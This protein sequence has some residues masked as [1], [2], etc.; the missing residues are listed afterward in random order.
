M[1]C[2]DKVPGVI[3]RQI[4]NALILML[5]FN[6]LVW[7]LCL[8]ICR[9]NGIHC[10]LCDKYCVSGVQDRLP[11]WSPRS[12]QVSHLEGNERHT[13]E[14]VRKYKSEESH[15]DFKTQGKRHKEWHQLLH[16]RTNVLQN[17]YQKICFSWHYGHMFHLVKHCA[18][19]LEW[20]LCTTCQSSQIISNHGR[21]N[22]DYLTGICGS[23]TWLKNE[24]N[25]QLQ[26]IWEV[27]SICDKLYVEP[28]VEC[29]NGAFSATRKS[30]LF[31]RQQ[32]DLNK[33]SLKRVDNSV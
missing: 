31:C 5:C 18:T 27:K 2:N 19:L 25:C 9:K 1:L 7:V 11:C 33:H 30:T 21:E 16:K 24:E 29:T 12:Q 22:V 4:A 17:F 28:S 10:L 13:G 14:E 15:S 23:W 26:C 20:N 8:R 3:N 32:F 6:I